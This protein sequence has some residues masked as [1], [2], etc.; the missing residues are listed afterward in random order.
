[1]GRTTLGVS[2]H[3]VR[4][5]TGLWSIWRR[6]RSPRNVR[7]ANHLGFGT[8]PPNAWRGFWRIHRD[9][10]PCAGYFRRIEVSRRGDPDVSCSFHYERLLVHIFYVVRQS[11]RNVCTSDDRHFRW[12][13]AKQRATVY[14][15]ADCW[16][17]CCRIV[18]ALVAQSGW[19]INRLI[20]TTKSDCI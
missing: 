12:N 13:L 6:S 18:R 11:C 17:R 10:W 16:C 14:W 15:R 5:G 7:T 9:F 2:W 3:R 4:A 8:Y 19:I 1:L 20:L